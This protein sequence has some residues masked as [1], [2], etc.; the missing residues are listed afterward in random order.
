MLAE[1][2][3]RDFIPCRRG[4]GSTQWEVGLRLGFRGGSGGSRDGFEDRGCS[5]SLLRKCERLIRIP[6][7]H[8]SRG[9]FLGY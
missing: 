8:T 6:S 3:Q 5:S 2:G 4:V 9:F 1:L 7:C